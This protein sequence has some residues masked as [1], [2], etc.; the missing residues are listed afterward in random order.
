[1]N[2]SRKTPSFPSN[3]SF[4]MRWIA[5]RVSSN[6]S[7]AL[8][9][10][11]SQTFLERDGLP[12]GPLSST[13]RNNAPDASYSFRAKPDSAEGNNDGSRAHERCRNQTWPPDDQSGG[14]GLGGVAGLALGGGAGVGGGW[15]VRGETFPAP[16]IATRSTS[17]R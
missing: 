13:Q 15:A 17:I 14:A 3:A 4:N 11:S 10:E 2:G 12:H 5:R 1:M 9:G 8:M 16:T 6:S 7:S